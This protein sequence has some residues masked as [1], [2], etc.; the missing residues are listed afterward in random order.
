MMS[1]AMGTLRRLLRPLGL[2]AALWILLVPAR[3]V[4]QASSFQIQMRVG[5]DEESTQVLRVGEDF[6]VEVLLTAQSRRGGFKSSFYKN[7][8][9]PQ[10][11]A[12]LT[13]VDRSESTRSS[14]AIV[15]GRY[16]QEFS[17]VMS[18]VVRPVKEG[19]HTIGPATMEAEGRLYKSDGVMVSILPPRAAPKA[20]IEGQE[21]DP[22]LAEDEFF[23]VTVSR[24]QLVLGQ[25]VMVSWYLYTTSRLTERP[26]SDPPESQGFFSKSLFSQNHTYEM[27]R[28][29]LGQ[30]VFYRTLVF[31][32]MYW[33]QRTG[34]L[35]IAP[36]TVS[37]RT[38]SGF[39]NTGKTESRTSAEVAFDVKPLPTAG[40]PAGFVED[41]VGVYRMR[42]DLASGSLK[43]GDAVD[44]TITV[45]GEGLMTACRGPVLPQLA[46]ARLEPNGSPA[47]TENVENEEKVVGVWKARYVF[48]ATA[49]GSHEFPA[50]QLPYFDPVEG[51]YRTA[52]TSPVRLTVAP[53]PPGAR[54]P[55]PSTASPAASAQES[56][57]LAPR[58]KPPA[59]TDVTG[60]SLRARFWKGSW[61]WIAVALPPLAWLVVGIF[62][63]VRRRRLADVGGQRRRAIRA[64]R[65]EGVAR[66][67]AALRAGRR[68]DFFGEC[69]RLLTD[70]LTEVVGRSATGLVHAELRSALEE[71]EVPGELTG[72]ALETLEGFDFARYAP[73][74]GQLASEGPAQLEKTLQLVHR[75]DAFVEKSR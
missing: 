48:I 70:T 67:R 22:A 3:V 31:R 30:A 55:P 64:R 17:H 50:L 9:A 11:P 2:V 28:V 25:P 39:L 54:V 51:A 8:T 36:R 19:R 60:S 32:R 62:R 15:N 10:F 58:L 71:R 27:E 16:T 24:D 37:Y 38:R 52:A 56:N 53:A 47:I 65:R 1:P 4:A 12:G 72:E 68:E 45:E 7:Y 41:H 44:L 6:V 21:P 40:R 74:Q 59:V 69:A 14:V 42:L 57:V 35:T 43:V 23:Q 5:Q 20:I 66:A 13:V 29:Q 63:I 18:Y 61:R 49:E 46:W 33:P 34:S 73:G 26:Q 75:L